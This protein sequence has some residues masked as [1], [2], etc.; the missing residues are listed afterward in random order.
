MAECWPLPQSE[1]RDG[2]PALYICA[3][4]ARVSEFWNR[5]ILGLLL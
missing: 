3:G 2:F 1:K 5:G 4:A